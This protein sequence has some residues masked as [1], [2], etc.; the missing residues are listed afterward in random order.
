MCYT[1]RLVLCI[2]SFGWVLC[3]HFKSV[4]I[5]LHKL[6]VTNKQTKQRELISEAP[7]GTRRVLM[8]NS[9]V[10][11][12][13]TL[14][15]VML[16]ILT[17]ISMKNLTKITRITSFKRKH[18]NSLVIFH[19]RRFSESFNVQGIGRLV[20]EN[21]LTGVATNGPHIRLPYKCPQILF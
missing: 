5:L 10:N 11:M 8:I 17:I 14:I 6:S 12:A 20:V 13:K 2:F 16:A 3:V 19:T 21:P 7:T 15:A 9:T 1:F 18:L 4:N